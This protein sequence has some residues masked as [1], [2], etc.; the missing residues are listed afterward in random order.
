MFRSSPPQD[1][2][3][4]TQGEGRRGPRVRFAD[5]EE[6]NGPLEVLCG[7]LSAVLAVTCLAGLGTM[8]AVLYMTVRPFSVPSY[9]RLACQLGASAFLEAAALLLPNT[10]M[11]LT[12]DSDIPSPIGT[13]LLVSNHAVHADWWV[14][15]ML[16]R[17]VGLRGSMKYFLRNEYLNVDVQKE[18]PDGYSRTKLTNGSALS[19]SRPSENGNG[20]AQRR[21]SA[22]AS[23][24]NANHR[25]APPDLSLAAKLLHILLD[26]PLLVNGDDYTADREQLFQLLRSFTE[27]PSVP[28]HLML[29]PESWSMYNG[30]DRD[31]L[32]A[33]SNT[34]AR[35]EGR[36]HLKHLLLPRTRGFNATLECLRESNPVVYDVTMVR[37][38]SQGRFSAL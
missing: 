36:P 18:S 19:S 26:F 21:P 3:T 1:S 35:R 24:T 38:W 17:C 2:H 12:G 10:K 25:V 27:G 30:A 28:V 4:P 23:T 22:S 37:R 5:A 6:Q 29:F 20:A 32:L 34:F 14:M 15:L 16:G 31:F 9:R 11:Y 13:S 33:K 8:L 7:I